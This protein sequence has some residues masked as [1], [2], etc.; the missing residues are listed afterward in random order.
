[1]SDPRIK[2]GDT[3]RV[4]R[5]PCCPGAIGKYG[6]VA[7]FSQRSIDAPAG[8]CTHC[9]EQH[10]EVEVLV[11][12]DSGR[13]WPLPWVEK[14]PPLSELGMTNEDEKLVVPRSGN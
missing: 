14:V 6:I 5:W 3:V 7:A 13:H 2:Q 1:M 11:I 4:A 8:R 12:T 10:P 9:G